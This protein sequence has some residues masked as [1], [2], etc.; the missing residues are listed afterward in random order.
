M[1]RFVAPPLPTGLGDLAALLDVIRD[2]EKYE[3]A[4][5]AFINLHN[6]AEEASQKANKEVSRFEQEALAHKNSVE[7]SKKHEHS[8]NVAVQNLAREREAFRIERTDLKNQLT[9]ERAELAECTKA[10]DLVAAEQAIRSQS[11]EDVLT[12]AYGSTNARAWI[13]PASTP[14]PVWTPC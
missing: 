13:M 11:L 2:P 3:K 12:K 4:L 10:L 14:H 6:E 8:C 5:R 9:Q 1:P 7:L